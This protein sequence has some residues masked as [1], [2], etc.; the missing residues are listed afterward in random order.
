MFV[1][2]GNND[3]VRPILY[4]DE[5]NPHSR[6]VLMILNMLDVDVELRP[7]EMV[8]GEHLKPAYSKINPAHTVPTLV[9]KDLAITGNAIFS[10]VCENN[11]NEKASQLIA[12]KC[13]KRHCCVMSRLFFESQVL[14]R[15][16]G[17]LMTDLVRQ[18][19]FQSD[20]EYHQKKVEHAYDVME[21]YLNDGAFMAGSV[22]TAAD[23]SFLACLGALDMMF[24]IDVD[25]QRWQKLND[26]FRRMRSL[27]IQKINS[28]GIEK[29]RQIVEHFSKFP[30]T[31]D[32]KRFTIGVRDS[33]IPRFPERPDRCSVSVQTVDRQEITANTGQHLEDT[34][35]QNVQPEPSGT[36]DRDGS[37][38]TPT[39]DIDLISANKTVKVPTEEMTKILTSPLNENPLP[40]PVSTEA[41]NYP[42]P[43]PIEQE[44][45]EPMDSFTVKPVVTAQYLHV[46]NGPIPAGSFGGAHKVK[47]PVPPKRKKN[48]TSTAVSPPGEKA[49]A[50]KPVIM[51]AENQSHSLTRLNGGIESTVLI[52]VPQEKD[53]II[54]PLVVS[55]LISST[56]LAGANLTTKKSETTMTAQEVNLSDID[57]EEF[58]KASQKL[59]STVSDFLPPPLLIND[60]QV[61]LSYNRGTAAP[62]L[63]LAVP[64]PSPENH[65]QDE[66]LEDQFPPPPSELLIPK[67]TSRAKAP[68]ST[69]LVCVKGAGESNEKALRKA[70]GAKP[71]STNESTT[72]HAGKIFSDSKSHAARKSLAPESKICKPTR[73]VNRGGL[74]ASGTKSP[75]SNISQASLLA[76]Q[77][78]NVS[79]KEAK[80]VWKKIPVK[81]LP[82]AKIMDK[83]TAPPNSG[84]GIKTLDSTES[85]AK[86][87]QKASGRIAKYNG[88]KVFK[89]KNNEKQ[90]RVE[91]GGQAA[92]KGKTLSPAADVVTEFLSSKVDKLD[93][94]TTEVVDKPKKKES[95]ASTTNR[96]QSNTASSPSPT[97]NFDTSPFMPGLEFIK[98]PAKKV[99]ERKLIGKMRRKKVSK[100][101]SQQVTNQRQLSPPVPLTVT[102]PEIIEQ[103]IEVLN[104]SLEQTT[105]S[106]ALTSPQHNVAERSADAPVSVG[107]VA[108]LLQTLGAA[109]A[110]ATPP[111]YQTNKE[112]P[113]SPPPAL[114]PLPSETFYQDLP[115][116]LPPLPPPPT[117]NFPPNDALPQAGTVAKALQSLSAVTADTKPIC[118]TFKPFHKVELQ[119]KA[120]EKPVPSEV[121]STV[122]KGSIPCVAE[123]SKPLAE[124]LTATV[125]HLH[126]DNIDKAEKTVLIDDKQ[127]LKKNKTDSDVLLVKEN[128]VTEKLELHKIESVKPVPYTMGMPPTCVNFLMDDLLV[129]ENAQKEQKELN[130]PE[131]SLKE[132]LL[133]SARE[134]IISQ[135]QP[136]HAPDFSSSAITGIPKLP[137]G[138]VKTTDASK[139][140]SQ[141]PKNY[142]YILGRAMIE[143]GLEYMELTP[144]HR[145]PNIFITGYTRVQPKTIDS[146]FV[147]RGRPT[148]VSMPNTFGVRPKGLCTHGPSAN[149]V[150]STFGYTPMSELESIPENLLPPNVKPIYDKILGAPS[151]V[152]STS[153]VMSIT[154]TTTT[155]ASLTPI[156]PKSEI[157]QMQIYSS[158]IKSERPYPTAHRSRTDRAN[159]R[160]ININGRVV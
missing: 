48:V 45:I 153:N 123:E 29:Q 71:A 34:L 85:T 134:E 27:S 136:T 93:K 22:L 156:A 86:G 143:D 107:L 91:G 112:L 126:R 155:S 151:K 105:L 98:S 145:Q 125:Q 18:T 15:I 106:S 55:R 82:N 79:T 16:H 49:E 39:E 66:K 56:D 2:D 130:I 43:P 109:T 159:E 108:K 3:H 9:H 31:S 135:T 10:Y 73:K 40:A 37:R 20:I 68:R 47:P 152:A 53:I 157:E 61:A 14:H 115:M 32:V 147:G 44:R 160:G 114:P 81:I 50:K 70:S 57:N 120:P 131:K 141:D 60:K 58:S 83:K 110:N 62:N 138:L 59:I 124:I 46:R 72:R 117:S 142:R 67:P 132:T 51:E 42:P 95:S 94:S 35:H 28:N 104:D 96:I 149:V 100:V 102:A 133:L 90:Q 154:D 148:S 19:I 150:L 33:L 38:S 17:H 122:P 111:S 84:S 113:P 26:W 78:R 139:Y 36:S 23:I 65:S 12:L 137:K 89:P 1:N 52:E 54:P 88:I 129:H 75:C 101:V 144:L 140:L 80:S 128:P 30:F 92:F 7:I 158:R 63:T 116:P 103:Q 146:L 74:F 41:P 21:A 121:I 69:K 6:A 25:R 64:P 127:S 76:Q 119:T 8:R 87:I 4:Y 118:G 77:N 24:P 11:D 13:Y 97:K 99:G 5:I